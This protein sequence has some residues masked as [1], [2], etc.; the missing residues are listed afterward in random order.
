MRRLVYALG[1]PL[2]PVVTLSRV[3]KGVRETARRQSLP[4]GMVPALMLGAM[5]K[6]A[7]EMRGYL[8]GIPESA[9]EEMTGY[10]VRKLAFN[11]G[12]ES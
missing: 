6:A 8:L 12:Q 3:R 10:E 4:K 1:S 2:I 7:G 5:V 9:E 11:S